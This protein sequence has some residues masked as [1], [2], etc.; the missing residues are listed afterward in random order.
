MTEDLSRFA[1]SVILKLPKHPKRAK[2]SIFNKFIYKYIGEENIEILRPLTRPYEWEL[3]LKSKDIREKLLRI[4]KTKVKKLT[5]SI[6]PF[7]TSEIRGSILW[8]PSAV[9]N[10]IVKE[11][12]SQYGQIIFVEYRNNQNWDRTIGNETRYY[13]LYLH[14]NVRKSDIPHFKKFGEFQCL[15]T[16]HGRRPECFYCKGWGH[17]KSECK[18][19]QKKLNSLCRR[20]PYSRSDA[21]NES[22]AGTNV[23]SYSSTASFVSSQVF[24]ESESSASSSTT[25]FDGTVELCIKSKSSDASNSTSTSSS[26]TSTALVPTSEVCAVSKCTAYKSTTVADTSQISSDNEPLALTS[27]LITSQVCSKSQSSVTSFT[28]D[29]SVVLQNCSENELNAAFNPI[30][31]GNSN[32]QDCTEDGNSCKSISK[33]ATVST[34]QVCPIWSSVNNKIGIEKQIFMAIQYLDQWKIDLAKSIE[35]SFKI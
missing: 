22:K 5:C 34:S 15:I 6:I 2:P 32:S 27:T 25:M 1:M 21:S 17:K 18:L 7:S 11:F 12:L 33:D 3:V 19:H 9:S 14:E 35:D 26:S 16:V 4:R 23:A 31:L 24:T 10:D 20:P 29:T 30:I 28:A 13:S 8:L